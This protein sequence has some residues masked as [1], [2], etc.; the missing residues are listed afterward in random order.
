MSGQ[1]LR[2]V[3]VLGIVV[4]AIGAAYLARKLA[5][6][7]HPA[8]TVGEVGDRPGVVL[9]TST[10]CSNCKE[11]IATLERASIPFREV[12]YDLEPHRFVAWDVLAVPMTVVVDGDGKLIEAISG[13]PRRKVLTRAVQAAGIA[14]P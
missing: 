6:P 12:T 14:I 10:D 3:F 11:A 5:K 13:V 4:V 9:F 7:V 2:L 1:V 8:I